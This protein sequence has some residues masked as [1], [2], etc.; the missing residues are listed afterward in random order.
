MFSLKPISLVLLASLLSACG[1]GGGG[2]TSTDPAPTLALSSNWNSYLQQTGSVNYSISGSLNAVQVSGTG[3]YIKNYSNPTSLL[4]IN[5]S[6]PFAGPGPSITWNNL[7][8]SLFEFA[9]TIVTSGGNSLVYGTDNWYYDANGNLKV[10][11]NVEDNE[12]TLISN[13]TAFPAQVTAGSSGQFFTGTVYSRLGY[14]CGTQTGTYS[15]TARSSTS[16]NLK[17]TINSS[18]TEQ[19]VGQCSTDVSTTEYNYALT[20]S[21][22]NLLSVVSSSNSIAGSLTFTF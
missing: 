13:F 3:E 6:N 16:L 21:N 5:T 2:T 8:R 4:V 7:S 17:I 12:Q 15:V 1:G 20:S 22:I 11:W 18:T 10:I 14:T 19:A 9:S